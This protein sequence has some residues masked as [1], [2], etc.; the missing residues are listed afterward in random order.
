MTAFTRQADPA[1]ID[2]NKMRHAKAG[3]RAINGNRFAFHRL[4]AAELDQMLFF[5]ASG[6]AHRHGG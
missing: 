6:V 1:L 3:T 5:L 4:S 2:V